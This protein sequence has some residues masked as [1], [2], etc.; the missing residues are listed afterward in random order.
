[1]VIIAPFPAV[2]YAELPTMFVDFTFAK[3][4]EPQARL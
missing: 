1:M 4:L 3:M 2:E